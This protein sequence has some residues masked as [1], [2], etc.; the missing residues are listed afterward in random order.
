MIES[1]KRANLWSDDYE[2]DASDPDGYRAAM[3][4]VG[5]TAGGDELA[6]KAFEL[7]PGESL[8]PYHYEYVE[9]WLLVLDGSVLVRVPQGEHE[10]QRGDLVCFARGAEGGHKVSNSGE[11]TARVLMFSS[12]REPSVAVYPDSDKIGVWPGD[13]ADTLMLRR[14]DGHVD[15]YDGER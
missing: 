6:V 12:A 7:P 4:H 13:S 10:L 3:A 8:C 15:Y 1:M 11:Q 14:A 2:L 9:E 5:K